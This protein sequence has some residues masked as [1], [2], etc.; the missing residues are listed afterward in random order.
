MAARDD[1]GACACGR[2]AFGI[3]HPLIA[4]HDIARVRQRLCGIGFDMTPVGRHPWGT[5]TAL[6]VFPN[7]LLEI[8]GI[9]DE[10]LLD[11]SAS[12][13][14]RFGRHVHKHLLEREGVA[15]TAL[16]SLGTE[17]DAVRAREAGFE[18]VGQI[19]FGRD[20]TLPDG[21]AERT[22]TTL[23]PLPDREHPRLS[24]FLCH[25]HR[26]DLVEVARWMAHPNAVVGIDGVTVLADASLHERLGRRFGALYGR[27]ESAAGGFDVRTANGTISIR[28]REAIER[29]FLAPLPEAIDV[30]SPAVVAMTLRSADMGR[31]DAALADSGVEVRES[32]GARVLVEA[33][34]L[35][36]TFL[37]FRA[38]RP[39]ARRR[40]GAARV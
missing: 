2:A 21:R 20:V 37:R 17:A 25:Q 1:D 16:H 3:D 22:R 34:L 19:D 27:T 23:A 10:R 29:A 40:Y 18:V 31:T 33:S 13:D 36:N 38:A 30:S 39:T 35:G 4:V 5:A 12:G 14:F 11:E 24:F 7:C 26:R 15:L 32:D 28:T 8:V 6:A 9:Y